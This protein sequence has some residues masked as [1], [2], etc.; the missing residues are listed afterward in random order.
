[1]ISVAGYRGLWQLFTRPFFWEKTEHG[2]AKT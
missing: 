2:V 1:M